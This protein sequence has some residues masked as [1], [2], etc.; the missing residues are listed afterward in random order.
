MKREA[1][2]VKISDDHVTILRNILGE[3]VY[4]LYANKLQVEGKNGGY[5]YWADEFAVAFSTVNS[6]SEKF[7]SYINISAD[8]KLSPHSATTYYEFKIN[9]SS[10]PLWQEGALQFG[11]LSSIKVFSDPILMIE[12]YQACCEEG[13]KSTLHDCAMLFYSQSRK[14]LLKSRAELIGGV[15]VVLDEAFIE[16]LIQ[17]CKLRYTLV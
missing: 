3:R 17:D 15:D 16:T 2:L 10:A 8:Y 11:R 9:E 14:F 12:I 5:T 13:E 7:R 6:P 1:E 4:F